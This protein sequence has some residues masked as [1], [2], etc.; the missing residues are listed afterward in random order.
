MLKPLTFLTAAL[1][2]MPGPAAAASLV[3]FSMAGEHSAEFDLRQ[4]PTPASFVTGS[5]FVLDGI[6]G[7]FENAAG[8]ASIR[9]FNDSLGGGLEI[10]GDFVGHY[11][12]LYAGSERA[13]SIYTGD[14]QLIDAA[15]RGQ[16]G[17]IIFPNGS[18]A[19]VPEP[20][21]WVM[22]VAGFGLVGSALRRRPAIAGAR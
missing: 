22:L 6:A 5:S 10:I 13:P 1:V 7:T 20:A 19:D 21:G 12:Q 17:L 16:S 18:I 4:S 9:F 8:T 15:T 14:Y 3:H 2:A 11:N